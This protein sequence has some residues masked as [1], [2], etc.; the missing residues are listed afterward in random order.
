LFQTIDGMRMGI[1]R[2]WLWRS[3]SSWIWCHIKLHGI[4]P[5]TIALIFLELQS[6]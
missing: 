3:V 5:Q 6:E 2:W 4:T 1:S